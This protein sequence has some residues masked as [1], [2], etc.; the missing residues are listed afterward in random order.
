MGNIKQ[1][2]DTC[3]RRHP[4]CRKGLSGVNFR[5]LELNILPSRVVDVGLGGSSQ[6]RVV[7]TN[8]KRGRYCALSY[9][10]GP[11][12]PNDNRTTLRSDTLD[13]FLQALPVPELPRTIQEAIDVTRRIG[14]SYLWVDRL[15]IIQNNDAD[16]KKECDQMCN[17]YEGAFLTLATLGDDTG[18][19]GFFLDREV[20]D[21]PT[22]VIHEAENEE[23]P[24]WRVKLPC[25]IKDKPLG[26]AYLGNALNSFSDNPRP[27]R[28]SKS[29]FD[30]ELEAS[31][32]VT[33]GWI[34]QERLLSR[35][36]VYFGKRQLYWECGTAFRNEDGTASGPDHF[37]VHEVGFPKQGFTEKL[38][39]PFT[40]LF[41]GKFGI[42]QH[43]A[44]AELVGHYSS[45]NLSQPTDKL[46]AVNGVAEALRRRFSLNGYYHGI[47]AE[48]LSHGLTW[49]S[50][51]TLTRRSGEQYSIGKD[52]VDIRWLI[53]TDTNPSW[54]WAGWDGE[55]LYKHRVTENAIQC[56]K[57]AEF[58]EIDTNPALKL[59]VAMVPIQPRRVHNDKGD[60]D[61]RIDEFAEWVEIVTNFS[62]S[63]FSVWPWLMRNKSVG[64]N[65]IAT[66]DSRPVGVIKYDNFLDPADGCASLLLSCEQEPF[67]EKSEVYWYYFLVLEKMEDGPSGAKRFRRVGLGEGVWAREDNV[68]FPFHNQPETDVVIL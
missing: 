7:E 68:G 4:K 60:H 49:Y 46:R 14:I 1:W 38:S 63:E 67:A 44:W 59:T 50:V 3:F 28:D 53:N 10:W 12:A 8:G 11:P 31:R 54:S 35:R 26:E 17:I 56:V 6:V 18:T 65:A 37:N 58:G 36:I 61:G 2:L 51:N 40:G 5:W 23:Q 43:N 16:T 24:L 20:L 21:H 19:K 62:T 27:D 66:V 25:R 42:A 64:F 29:C 9:C 47:W 13:M 39:S 55:I 57:G 34:L 52:Q 22:T 48:Y 32:W 33:R 15:C 41:T 30:Q 45:R